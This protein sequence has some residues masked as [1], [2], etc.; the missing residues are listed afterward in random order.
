MDERT[1]DLA[2][3]I[4]AAW[5]LPKEAAALITMNYAQH[6]ERGTNYT[7]ARA[8]GAIE[9][10][11]AIDVISEKTND[12]AVILLGNICAAKTEDE[13]WKILNAHFTNDHIKED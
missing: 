12:E 2:L 9:A 13:A 11:R 3:N 6:A 1:L 7:L 10:F 4:A 8:L 5:E